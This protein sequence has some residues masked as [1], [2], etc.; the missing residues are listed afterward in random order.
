MLPYLDFGDGFLLRSL[1]F[2][3]FFFLI[4]WFDLFIANTVWP[5]KKILDFSSY[6][7]AQ[8]D[9]IVWASNSPSLKLKFWG[10]FVALIL[11]KSCL[12]LSSNYIPVHLLQETGACDYNTP[13]MLKITVRPGSGCKMKQQCLTLLSHR[14][15]LLHDFPFLIRSYVCVCVC[16]NCSSYTIALLFFLWLLWICGLWPKVRNLA[17]LE[18]NLISVSGI[19][20]ADKEIEIPGP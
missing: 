11:W 5:G 18:N 20:D 1:V 14:V 6:I 17:F 9:T 10:P 3:S 19:H 8:L 16:V 4:D 13:V 7:F 12:I 15:I 2:C